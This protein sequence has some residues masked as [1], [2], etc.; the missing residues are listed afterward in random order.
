[1]DENEARAL[2]THVHYKGGLYRVIGVAR[3]SETE[4]SLTVYEQLWPKERSLWVRPTL[5]FN[6]R[7]EEGQLRFRPLAI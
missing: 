5:M 7:L 1:M 3:H 4:E 6:E 2:A